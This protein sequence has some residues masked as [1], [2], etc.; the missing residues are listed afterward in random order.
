MRQTGS[1]RKNGKR[2]DEPFV[3]GRLECPDSQANSVRPASAAGQERSVASA[4]ASHSP[5]TK[6][7]LLLFF[8]ITAR[9]RA[10][11]TATCSCSRS[12]PLIS[13]CH[14]GSRR[15]RFEF[16]KSI[17]HNSSECLQVKDKKWQTSSLDGQ[18]GAS[19]KRRVTAVPT[20]ESPV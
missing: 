20:G 12:C 14:C 16:V 15:C 17:G 1:E 5:I 8:K 10:N 9:S 13:S 2:D 3:L 4:C 19:H 11:K 6:L 7:P 18:C